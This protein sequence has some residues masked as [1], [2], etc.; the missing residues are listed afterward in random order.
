MK[1]LNQ[2]VYAT[3]TTLRHGMYVMAFAFPLLLWLIGYFAYG[4]SLADSMSD[5]YFLMPQ[6]DKFSRVFPMTIWFVGLLFA[7]GSALYLYK[8][9]SKRENIILNIAGAC[10]LGVALVPMSHKDFPADATFSL[11]PSYMHGAFAITLFLCI[12]YVSIFCSKETVS[13]LNNPRLE[14]SYK[15]KYQLCAL[16]MV[17]SPLTALGKVCTT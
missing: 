14:K 12:A 2:H 11:L 13:R 16:L 1:D 3:Y 9:F 8:G 15:R 10:A 17:A 7:I 5:Y 6:S 4:I